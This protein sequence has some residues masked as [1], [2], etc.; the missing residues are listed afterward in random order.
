MAKIPIRK[1]QDELVTA[2]TVADSV[3]A[4]IIKNALEEHGIPCEIGGEH[5]GG[6]TGTLSIDIIVNESDAPLAKQII[7]DHN[8]Q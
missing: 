3:K 2:Y 7:T 1:P 6:F 8:L 5:Q 4:E